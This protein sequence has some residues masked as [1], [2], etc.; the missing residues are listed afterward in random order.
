MNELA[1]EYLDKAKYM[2]TEWEKMANDG[3]HYKLTFD[4]AGTWS[5]KYNLVWDQLLQTNIFAATIAE[6]EIN[7]L[8]PDQTKH[9]RSAA[10]QP[11]KPIPR[12]TG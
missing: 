10:G 6:K 9:L 4:K 8:L 7:R 11:A 2:A 1:K 3:D 5:Q 12:A